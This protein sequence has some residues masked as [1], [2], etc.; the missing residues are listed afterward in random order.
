MADEFTTYQLA[1]AFGWD[2]QAVRAW[3][4][5]QYVLPGIPASGKGTKAKWVREDVYALVLFKYL[6]DR[7]FNRKKARDIIKSIWFSESSGEWPIVKLLREVSKSPDIESKQELMDGFLDDM[8]KIDEGKDVEKTLKLSAN[9]IAF[10]RKG[11]AIVALPV[12]E[13]IRDLTVFA[14][15]DLAFFPKQLNQQYAF[16]DIFIVNFKKIRDMADSVLE[17]LES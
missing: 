3:V 13:N 14:S 6:L 11:D 15:G 5:A 16:D 10:C 4:D 7:G 1:K 12:G 8:R 2:Y 17:R 9:W